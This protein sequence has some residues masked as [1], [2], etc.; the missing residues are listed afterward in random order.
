MLRTNKG[1]IGE[2]INWVVATIIIIVV[3]LIF[4]YVSIAL[5]K[6]KSLDTGV[7]DN[8]EA[9]SVDLIKTKTEIAFSLKDTN[10]NKIEEWIALE[11]ENE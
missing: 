7:K 6:T 9:S 2:S 4:I 1:Q 8:S 11:N 5:G 3:L 10:K